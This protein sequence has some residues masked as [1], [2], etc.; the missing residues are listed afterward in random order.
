VQV[1][2]AC[3]EAR[4]AL[5]VAVHV[6]HQVPGDRLRVFAAPV[7]LS[8]EQPWLG[9]PALCLDAGLGPVAR[10][11]LRRAGYRIEYRG[12]APPPL[13]PPDA[14]RLEGLGT[15]DRA[16][17][18]AVRSH[19]RALL[20]YGPGVD[21]AR[22]VGQ[23]ARAW[24]DLT[25]TVL[26]ARRADAW[27][28]GRAL[29]A[30]LPD[31]SVVTG[32]GGPAEVGRVVV[33][34]Y[35]GLG[36]SARY[37]LPGYRVFDVSWLQII[38]VLDALEATSQV[39]WRWLHR[40]ERAR[41]YGLLPLGARPSPLEADLL[42]ALFGFQ[43]AAL[44]RHGHRERPVQVLRHPIMGG[45]R[46]LPGL[47][48]VPR[49][50]R[51]FWQ[52]AMRNRQVARLAAA[53]ASGT[54]HEV[55]GT[56]AADAA[57]GAVVLAANAE[58]ALA[59]AVRLP[60]D[61]LLFAGPDVYEEGLTPDQVRL[62]H[63]PTTPFRAGPLYAVATPAVLPHLDLP[64]AGV[65]VRADGGVGLPPLAPA[66]LIEPDD[67]PARPLL[68]VDFDNRHHPLLRRRAA[69]RRQAYAERGWFA[70]GVDPVQARVE[71]FLASRPPEGLR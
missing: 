71:Q 17:L 16:L 62:L 14:A 23:V 29:R 66:Q 19:E 54:A 12:Q 1:E 52:D 48:G 39:A 21:L 61:W 41:T 30:L 35:T 22:L 2:P 57:P 28:L 25:V 69:L 4:R 40:A 63:R 10:E 37:R 13:P 31:V 9:G 5:R 32:Q 49:Q 43:E 3:A 64:W 50:R 33:A 55:L 68:L 38:I 67:G 46:L 65:L 45:M 47:A 56:A 15:L 53:F 7:S 70:S 34:T 36:H 24:P 8:R 60:D 42:R 59:L 6:P 26:A 58:H 51:G 27:R 11:A 18:D 20:R 44:P